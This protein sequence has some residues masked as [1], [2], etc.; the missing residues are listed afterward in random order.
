MTADA[1]RRSAMLGNQNRRSYMKLRMTHRVVTKEAAD[2]RKRLSGATGMSAR[3]TRKAPRSVPAQVAHQV[4]RDRIRAIAMLIN[5]ATREAA[6]SPF[7]RLVKSRGSKGRP[8]S[9]HRF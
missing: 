9:G 2:T 6:A 7:V 5:A 3:A 8:H 4:P 1:E